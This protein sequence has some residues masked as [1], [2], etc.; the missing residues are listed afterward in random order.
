[1][2]GQGQRQCVRR[3]IR[4]RGTGQYYLRKDHWTDD[5]RAAKS[6]PSVTQALCTALEFR[7]PK[8]CDLVITPCEAGRPFI[9]LP[10]YCPRDPHALGQ[11]PGRMLGS[12]E[13]LGRDIQERQ[14]KIQ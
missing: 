9:H 7:S 12:E 11:E 14:R 3:L 4:D 13:S 5:W 1:M 10:L 8:N 6:F 2:V